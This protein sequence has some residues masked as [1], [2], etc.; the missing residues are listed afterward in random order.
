MIIGGS[1][2]ET[3]IVIMT[4][5]TRL[6]ALFSAVAISFPATFLQASAQANSPQTFAVTVEKISHGHIAIEPPLPADGKVAA[7]TTLN[8]TALPDEG[9]AVDSGYYLIPGPWQPA[10]REFATATF[11]VPV[12]R[13][14]HIGASFIEA[15]KLKGFKVTQDVVYAQPG[16]KKLKYDV[17]SPDD[18]KNLPCIVIIHGGGWVFN[19]EDIMRGLAR[20]LVR[21]GKY[22]IF[23]IDYRCIGTNDGDKTP[24]TLADI[25]EDVYGAIAHIQE[26]ASEYGADPKRIAVTGD[27]AG[28]HLS[29]AAINMVERIGD[30][31]FGKKEGVYQFKP[32]YIPAGKSIEQV[33]KEITEALKVAAPSYGVFSSGMLP[34]GTRDAKLSPDAIKAV[35]P[36]DNI[37]NVRQR[38]V[39]QF[40]LRGKL[41]FLIKDAEVQGYADALMTAGQRVEYVQVDGAGHAFF[42][43]KPDEQ[44]KATFEKFGVPY[45]AKMESFFDEVFYPGKSQSIK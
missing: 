45:A 11:Q 35:A 2:S 20:E 43:W 22:V 7:G 3:A 23:S 21:G 12:D 9:Y 24:N 36:M 18:A 13:D 39:P 19:T 34:K 8:V 33:R 31:G 29:A 4:R 16:V 42:D 28:G 10:Y 32:T 41:D 1:Q 6:L 26:H 17:Y 30:D 38:A 37:P 15:K 44:T 25:I 5:S 40:L 14:R 27:S